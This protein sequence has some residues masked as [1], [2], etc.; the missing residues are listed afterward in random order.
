[1]PARTRKRKT[2]EEEEAGAEQ[3]TKPATK[4]ARTT[5]RKPKAGQGDTTKSDTGASKKGRTSANS[6]SSTG[7]RKQAKPSASG[8][9]REIRKQAD[10]L[11]LML[12]N[13]LDGAGSHLGS[14]AARGSLFSSKVETILKET[15]DIGVNQAI[16]TRCVVF[17]SV[18]GR[19][20]HLQELMDEF[21]T[22]NKSSINIRKPTEGQQWAQDAENVAKVDKKAMEVAIQ[23]LNSVVIAGEYSNLSRAS[24]GSGSE[25]EQ[26]AWKWLEGGMPAAEDTWGSAARETVR[27]FAGITKL[28]S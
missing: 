6:G 14:G 18:H 3:I 23:M 28:L 5:K 10:D 22:I 13:R 11:L 2:S 17:E 8:A 26:A 25:V 20:K 16:D 27:A 12:E 19:I 1:M 7:G 21:D 15:G 24:A 4:T 9:K